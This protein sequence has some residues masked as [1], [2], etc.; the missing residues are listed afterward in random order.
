LRDHLV[1]RSDHRVIP[2]LNRSSQQ[3]VGDWTV[4]D[5]VNAAVVA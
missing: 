4:R 1:H 5:A 2:S 3:C